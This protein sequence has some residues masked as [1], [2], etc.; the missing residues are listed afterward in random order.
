MFVI[1]GWGFAT[2]HVFG[3]VLP[4]DCPN[5]HNEEFWVLKRVRRWFTLFF[6]PV[7]PYE[8]THAVMCPI[9]GVGSEVSGS[10]LKRAKLY[11]E[12]NAAFQAGSLSDDAYATRLSAISEATDAQVAKGVAQAIDVEI[13]VH[14]AP[15]QTVAAASGVRTAL[16]VP[17]PPVASAPVVEEARS[18]DEVNAFCV[19][20]ARKFDAAADFFCPRCG[21]AR[22]VVA[23][24]A[25]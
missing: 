12:T 4:V 22:A 10:E 6:V 7:F 9:C 8:S 15:S 18:P 5:C 11:A 24:E 25:R 1:F 19:K 20:C 13:P 3:A 16:S 17:P 14:S 21:T 23:R 2:T